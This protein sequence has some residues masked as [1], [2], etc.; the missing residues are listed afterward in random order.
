MRRNAQKESIPPSQNLARPP[1]ICPP[2]L[3]MCP[4]QN[5]S[6]PQ[7]YTP[8]HHHYMRHPHNLPLPPRIYPP[9]NI[10]MDSGTLPESTPPSQ[11]ILP[12]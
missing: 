12:F 7:E 3:D 5:L 11:N 6:L 9:L 4:F 8:L 1:R 2:P 10:H